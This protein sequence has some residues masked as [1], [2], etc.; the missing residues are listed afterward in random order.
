MLK[1]W[2]EFKV[3]VNSNDADAVANFL[4]ESGS[5]GIVEDSS[6]DK[7]RKT[8]SHTASS[9]HITAFIDISQTA[10]LSYW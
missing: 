4:I 1:E 5:N 10:L 3:T 8:C 9:P 7:K 6:P 2:I